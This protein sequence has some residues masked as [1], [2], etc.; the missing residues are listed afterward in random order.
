MIVIVDYGL[1]NIHNVKRAVAHLGY[2]VVLSRD[3]TTIQ[4]ADQLILPGVGHFKDAM[5]AIRQYEL[6][7]V[8]QQYD[9]PIIGI[10]LGMQLMYEEGEEGHVSGLG[11]LKGRITE[12]QTPYTVPHLGWNNL[13][14]SKT[15]LTQDVY[16]VHSYQAPM[17]EDVVAYAEYGTDI[18]GIVQNG[19]YIGIQFHPEKSGESGL[20]ILAQTLKGG[21]Q[22]A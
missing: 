22:H 5:T 1:G 21:W 3:P 14:S 4:A 18:P 8:L 11:L 2:E 6:D 10:C 19:R 7:Q 15:D 20:D 16:F 17:N 9:K 12:I 13:I